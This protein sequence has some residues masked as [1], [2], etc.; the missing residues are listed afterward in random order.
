MTITGCTLLLGLGDKQCS[1]NA[2]CVDSQLGDT[3]VDNICQ[4]K[5]YDNDGGKGCE[6]DRD[7]S[8]TSTPRCLR[9]YCVTSDVY[10]QWTCPAQTPA[11][12]D[13]VKY[14]FKVVEYLSRK[15]PA[16]LKVNACRNGDTNCASPVASFTDV[17]K[18]GSVVLTL[19]NGFQGFFE[20]LSDQ[21]PA[22][23]Y[24]TKPVVKDTENREVPALEPT[25]VAGLAGLAGLPF[26]DSKT[27]GVA[28]L[29]MIDCNLKPASGV[30]FEIKPSA[31]DLFYIIN[32]VPSKDA[33]QT[34]Y[35]GVDST[36]D[37]GFL[38]LDKGL[39]TFTAYLGVEADAPQL[40]QFIAQIRANT[41]TYIDLSF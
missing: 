36:G 12:T 11:T 10:S 21:L 5:S 20:V 7:C 16:N 1:S 18:T 9:N 35:D 27:K 39:Y 32:G 37:G 17:G 34:L 38:N 13:T 14:S 15:P 4:L 24:V 6:A 25:T 22:L 40:G 19:D 28:L 30:R 31:P 26:D 2:E 23:L 33:K 8:G 29:E 41:I 3:C